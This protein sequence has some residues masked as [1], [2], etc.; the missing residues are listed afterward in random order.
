EAFVASLSS[1]HMLFFL[2]GAAKGGFVVDEYRDEASGEL[3]K[4]EQGKLFV[5]KVV[6]KPHVRYA[7]AAPDRATEEHLHH[8]AHEQ[9]FIANSVRTDISVDLG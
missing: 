3:G 1:C 8:E 4:N 5:S 7:G 9:C 2:A 6:L